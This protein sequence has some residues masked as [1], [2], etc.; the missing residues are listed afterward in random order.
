MPTTT[1]TN[2]TTGKTDW[3]K[4]EIG[5]LWK[6]KAK[7]SGESYFTGT[8]TF[9]EAVKSGQQIQVILFSNKSK[10]TDNQPDVRVYISEKTAGFAST[11]E[12]Q[13][14]AKKTQ[15]V[16]QP[17]AEESDAGGVF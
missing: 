15:T 1:N 6:R 3:K 14:V 13:P 5:V 7:A 12:Q 8:L 4:N 16:T 17:V 11:T 9:Q 2:T 10:K